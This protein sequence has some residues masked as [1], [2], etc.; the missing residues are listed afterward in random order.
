M[1]TVNQDH[2]TPCSRC[3]EPVK[4]LDLFPQS[5]CIRC[6]YEDRRLDSITDLFNQISKGF[7]EPR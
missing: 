2:T 3:A 6:H 5:L 7:G 1:N 4:P